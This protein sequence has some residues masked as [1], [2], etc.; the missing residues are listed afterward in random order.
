MYKDEQGRYRTESLFWETSLVERRSKYPPEFTLKEQALTLPNG[1]VLPSMRT[2][3]L[4]MCDPMEVRFAYE[5]LGSWDHW[6]KL[7]KTSWF[8]EHINEWRK[9]LVLRLRASG[10][11][12]LLELA[13]SGPEAQKYQAAKFLIQEGWKTAN[14]KKASTK[15]KRESKGKGSRPDPALLKAA[16]KLGIKYN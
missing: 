3:Y 2:L 13:Q 8:K 15:T 4:E 14:T 16:E 9:E 1:T 6:Q 11:E 12:T 5:V 7:L 10:F